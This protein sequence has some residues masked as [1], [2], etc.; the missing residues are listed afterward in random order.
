VCYSACHDQALFCWDCEK[1][2]CLDCVALAKTDK[3][4]FREQE[5]SHHV[6]SL[7]AIVTATPYG[8]TPKKG[9][10]LKD[11]FRLGFQKFAK[12]PFLA[13]YG[14]PVPASR[15]GSC[16]FPASA[17][18]SPLRYAAQPCFPTVKSLFSWYSFEFVQNRADRFAHGLGHF[19]QLVK[20][21][22]GAKSSAQGGGAVE[23][24]SKRQQAVDKGFVAVGGPNCL[25][26]VVADLGC[27]FSDKVSVPLHTTLTT[28]ELVS[29]INNS[30][31][32]CAVVVSTMVDKILEVCPQCPTLSAVVEMDTAAHTSN[33]NSSKNSS[34]KG[35]FWRS[36]K[37]SSQSSSS[38]SRGE[39]AC[40]KVYARPTKQGSNIQPCTVTT[41]EGIELGPFLVKMTRN[42][43]N[44]RRHIGQTGTRA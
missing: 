25:S 12:R 27:L 36:G 32:W 43:E 40:V 8:H 21:A 31:L 42:R 37:S 15:V 26:W 22:T 6:I 35:K 29:I 14:S 10:T 34:S 3:K 24:S 28:E 30:G 4:A 13:E 1:T 33:K 16:M 39:G 5:H 7:E 41:A 23:W 44:G 18:V 2:V 17:E 19:A 38:K 20:A 9:N 11:T